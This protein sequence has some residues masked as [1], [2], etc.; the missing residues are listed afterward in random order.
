MDR[1]D[2]VTVAFDLMKAE[3]DGEVE[4]LND[5]G[6]KRF[7]GSEYLMAQELIN[8]GRDLQIFIKKVEA[9]ATEW[10]NEFA[11]VFPDEV[12]PN[13]IENARREIAITTKGPRTGLLVRFADGTVVSERTAAA[14]MAVVIEKIGLKNVIGLGLKLN[15]E[16]LVSE[17][18]SKNYGYENI[19][20]FYIMTHC[21]TDKKKQI[22]EQIAKKLSLSL[23]IRI[24]E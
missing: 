5:E 17:V 2:S 1:I 9:L 7:R 19:G 13:A 8:R 14:T 15:K 12:V 11:S 10:S 22:L 18:P 3:L 16:S 6:A 23:E 20:G 21:N 24:V 4:R